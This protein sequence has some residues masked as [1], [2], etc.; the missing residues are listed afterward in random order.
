[1]ESIWLLFFFVA[2]VAFTNWRYDYSVTPQKRTVLLLLPRDQHLGGKHLRGGSKARNQWLFLVPIKGGRWRHIIPQ[3]AVYPLIYIYILIYRIPLYI[4][5]WVVICYL[6][7][8]MGAR[9]NH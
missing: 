9:N 2:H 5:F 7:P 4:A 8:F 3:L 1:M 6:P